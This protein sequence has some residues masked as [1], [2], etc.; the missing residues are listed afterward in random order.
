M[1]KLFTESNILY[2]K[3]S[4]IFLDLISTNNNIFKGKI[5]ISDFPELNRICSI[6]GI[7]HVLNLNSHHLPN[8][9]IDCIVT[10]NIEDVSLESSIVGSD[11]AVPI[12][13]YSPSKKQQRI[14]CGVCNKS[15]N[16][17]NTRPISKYCSEKC[18][19]KDNG[20]SENNDGSIKTDIIKD[21]G[22]SNIVSRIMEKKKEEPLVLEFDKTLSNKKTVSNVKKT[23]D[24]F[25]QGMVKEAIRLGFAVKRETYKRE[26]RQPS[27]RKANLSNKKESKQEI[28][29]IVSVTKICKGITKKG[30]QCTNKA[31]G[32]SDYC[33]ILSHAMNSGKL[34]MEAME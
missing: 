4:Q 29:D 28:V 3:K 5:I 33:G 1:I 17:E 13:Y 22:L 20:F 11:Y 2:F 18:M 32:S 27:L 7:I 24:K 30:K 25:Q 19:R 14:W 15:Y 9:K 26:M 21:L 34:V 16:N 6:N 10:D 8:E 12:L 31:I 23:V